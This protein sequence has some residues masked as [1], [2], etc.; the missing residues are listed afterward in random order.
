MKGQDLLSETPYLHDGEYEAPEVLKS[1]T[2]MSDATLLRDHSPLD[3]YVVNAERIEFFFSKTQRVVTGVIKKKKEKTKEMSNLVV[4]SLRFKKEK[5]IVN[6]PNGVD[7]HKVLQVDSV[8]TDED[9]RGR[10]IS[11]FVYALLVE[12][13]FIIVSDTSQFDDGKQLW[14]K[15]SREAQFNDYVIHIIDDE[16]GFVKDKSGKIISYDSSNI[17]DAK[18]WSSGMDFRGEHILLMME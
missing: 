12:K 2:F 6:Y 16:N 8:Y 7:Q 14:K 4:F 3:Y 10:G 5:T 17:D 18:I 15:I 11:S 1:Q 9:Y 13:G